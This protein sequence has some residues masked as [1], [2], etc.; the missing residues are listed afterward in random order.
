MSSKII[1]IVIV[2]SI[3]CIGIGLYYR[4]IRIAPIKYSYEY[5]YKN[6]TRNERYADKIDIEKV[7]SYLPSKWFHIK[8]YKP[9]MYSD[10]TIWI[11]IWV[12]TPS[13]HDMIM[14]T[15]FTDRTNESFIQY[16]DKVYKLDHDDITFIESVIKAKK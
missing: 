2:I 4:P 15:Y 12:K 16:K 9:K 5:L 14:I 10:T 6:E 1:N 13:K 7:V 3:I 8:G 11:Y